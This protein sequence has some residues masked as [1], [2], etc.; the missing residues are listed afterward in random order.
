M[1]SNIWNEDVP[2]GDWSQGPIS[3]TSY[4]LMYG[5]LGLSEDAS[6]PESGNSYTPLSMHECFAEPDGGPST[7]SH[8]PFPYLGCPLNHNDY[9][10]SGSMSPELDWFINPI[11][12]SPSFKCHP[13]H[14][15]QWH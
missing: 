8:E 2:S 6:S 14:P 1:D 5:E 10:P 15:T 12:E 11:S 4:L 3:G 9:D 13:V 7:F